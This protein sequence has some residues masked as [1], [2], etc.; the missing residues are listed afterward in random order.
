VNA[1]GGAWAV[2]VIVDED[3]EVYA[4]WGLGV[5]TTYHLLNPWTQV[6][7]RKLGTQEGLW[8]REVDPSGNRW[9]VG[10]AWSADEGERVSSLFRNTLRAIFFF[11]F[12]R[13]STDY[14][15]SGQH[16]MGSGEQD[17]R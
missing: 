4:S 17:G 10:G 3:R 6:A 16:S 7:M 2:T 12:E 14:I 15:G 11:F 9:Q 8:A 13:C 5:S 1:I